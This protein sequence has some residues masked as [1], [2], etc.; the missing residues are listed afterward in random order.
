MSNLKH[1]GLVP[2]RRRFLQSA[3]ALAGTPYPVG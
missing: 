1:D 2:S 3:G